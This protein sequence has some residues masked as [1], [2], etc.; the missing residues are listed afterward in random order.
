[1]QWILYGCYL[2]QIFSAYGLIEDV[3]IVRDELKQSRGVFLI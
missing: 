3:Y 2:C 1:M